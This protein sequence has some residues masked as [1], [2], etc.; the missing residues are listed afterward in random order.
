ML[1]LFIF[2]EK[3]NA[4]IPEIAYNG[5]SA[6][7][8]LTVTEDVTI[9]P[10]EARF[11]ENGLRITID[12][13]E[14]YYMQVFPRSSA[15]IKRNLRCHPGIIDAGYTGPFGTYFYNLGD[16]PCV[17]KAGE[18]LAQVVI[19]KKHPF[20]FK[21]LNEAEFKE[22]ESKQQRGS[23]GFGSSGDAGNAGVAGRISEGS[24]TIQN[25][26]NSKV[27]ELQK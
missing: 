22:L 17:I 16:E 18:R 8:D 13:S 21:E 5:T 12:E 19:H 25:I 2:K 15:G 27:K 24:I 7:F 4:Q 9:P 10:K 11:V 23:K 26:A 6:A 1:N 3:E 20:V 14:P